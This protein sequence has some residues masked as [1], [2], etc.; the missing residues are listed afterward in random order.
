MNAQF[1]FPQNDPLGTGTRFH[2][3]E[4]NKWLRGVVASLFP[5]GLTRPF[6]GVSPE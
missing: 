4:A 2:H 5:G 3:D 1:E 6:W